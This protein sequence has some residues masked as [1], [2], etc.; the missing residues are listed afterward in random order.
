MGGLFEPVCNQEGEVGE[1]DAAV[2]GEVAG[3][4]A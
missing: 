3:V 4:D 1:V 2:A